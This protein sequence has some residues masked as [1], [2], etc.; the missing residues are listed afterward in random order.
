MPIAP[1]QRR[2]AQLQVNTAGAWETVLKFDATYEADA[3]RVQEAVQLLHQ[4]DQQPNWRI[5]TDGS[6]PVALRHLSRSTYGFWI[7]A[8][9]PHQ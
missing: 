8:K 9:E 2:P 4:V 5:T 6:H 7:D 1:A 3:S